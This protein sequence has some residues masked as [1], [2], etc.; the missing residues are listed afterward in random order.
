MKYI[1]YI[2][3]IFIIISGCKSPEHLSTDTTTPEWVN[4]H[5]LNS[6]Y[7][8][9]IGSASKKMDPVN[10]A[11]T[12]KKNAFDDLASE[13]S[14]NIKSE[15]FLNTMQVNKQV[16]EQFSSVIAT[17]SNERIEDFEVVDVYETPTDYFIYYRLSKATHAAIKAERKKMALNAAADQYQK[18]LKSANEGQVN[19]AL[20]FL[21]KGLF[22]M[23]EYWNDV[24]PYVVDGEEVYL[25]LAIYGKI[26]EIVQS[27]KL[28]ANIP[29]IQLNSS[30]GFRQDVIVTAQLNEK[31]SA[32]LP[33]TASFDNG[34][35]RNQMK[36]VTDVNGTATIAVMNVNTLNPHLQLELIPDL[37]EMTPSGLD[38][39]LVKP[40]MEGL[41]V[42]KSVYPITVTM[43]VVACFYQ[44]SN[45]G[46]EVSQPYLA[47]PLQQSL[48]KKGFQFTDRLD[49]A[50]YVIYVEA[51]TKKGG[52][53][54]GFHV[55]FLEM[56]IVVRNK[57]GD[58]VYRNSLQNVKGL[59]LNFQ[60]AGIEAFKKG[61]KAIEKEIGNEITEA[62]L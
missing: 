24:N 54:Q 42:Q 56:H 51:S 1:F 30:N 57:I 59:Q 55:A 32:G 58:I 50:E 19:S 37:K 60:A 12:A 3:S 2:L 9:G 38:P 31:P 8:I 4:S 34:R 14:V 29:D 5:P 62:I 23:K 48:A 6:A 26:Q 20:D 7:Y 27:V 28:V 43:P 21:F 46:K 41:N 25:D 36:L 17:S 16:Q 33:F 45:L 40:I 22:E 10:Y 49:A 15:S 18:G 44:E 53:S 61:A 39:L 47:S 11:Q 35:F 13:I 52:T